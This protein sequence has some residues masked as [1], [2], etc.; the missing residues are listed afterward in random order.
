MS[1]HESSKYFG[2]A[3]QI[4][5]DIINIA[6]ENYFSS[7]GLADDFHEQKLS[8]L[9]LDYMRNESLSFEEKENF[10]KIFKK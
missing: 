4:N 6:E 8:Y 7:K 1:I 10:W 2:I 5:D 3:F 9:I